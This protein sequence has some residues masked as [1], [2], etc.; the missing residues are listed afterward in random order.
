MTLLESI[1]G[2][3]GRIT[4][5]NDLQRSVHERQTAAER[6]RELKDRNNS[7]SESMRPLQWLGVKRS[8]Y[9][10]AV[11]TAKQNVAKF[12]QAL[13]EGKSVEVLTKGQSWTQFLANLNGSS[14]AIQEI[15]KTKWKERINNVAN[16]PHPDEISRT[17]GGTP[18]NLQVLNEYSAQYAGLAE[19]MRLPVPGKKE[20]LSDMSVRADKLR[21]IRDK[22]DFSV[23]PAVKEF[24]DAASSDGAS[25][26]LISDEVRAW[27]D[28]HKL[29]GHYVV[30]VKGR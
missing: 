2:L 19:L 18:K 23:P 12:K 4:G 14:R 3:R 5:L 13:A 8:E 30:R 20:D 17:L 29:A 9:A 6:N 22:F 27:L 10:A 1:R 7:L 28:E 25:L 15:A 16:L 24:L 26:R 11:V 21:E